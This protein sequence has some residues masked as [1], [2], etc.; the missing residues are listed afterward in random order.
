MKV[1]D[2]VKALEDLS[3]KNLLVVKTP[4]LGRTYSFRPMTVGLRKSMSKFAIGDASGGVDFQIAKMG[5]LKT[6]C[7]DDFKEDE[8]SETDFIYLLAELRRHN[9]SD[10]LVVNIRCGKCKERFNHT[11]DFDRIVRKCA[12]YK[13]STSEFD[14]KDR[15][16]ISYNF[17]LGEPSMMDLITYRKFTVD[18]DSTAAA[19]TLPYLYIRNVA[20]NSSVVEDYASRDLVERMRFIESLPSEVLYNEERNL[21]DH[22]IT[23]F[24]NRSDKVN[25]VYGQLA[26]PKCGADLGGVVNTDSFFIV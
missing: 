12:E 5:L 25:D 16:G 23:V 2:V 21:I 9:F 19:L 1:D 26:C 3:G 4:G 7:T 11:L 18:E 6:L 15:M 8:V 13:F 17:L 22:I 20:V 10:K 24:G 14:I